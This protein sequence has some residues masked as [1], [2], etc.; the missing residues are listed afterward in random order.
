[1]KKV[2]ALLLFSTT[3]L[4]PACTPKYEM[5]NG[6]EIRPET[7]CSKFALNRAYL[8]GANLSK[9]KLNGVSLR[10]ADLRRAVLSGA[11]LSQADLREANLSKTH[12]IWT[13]LRGADLSG[14][15]LHEAIYEDSTILPEGFDPDAKGM[16]L[17]EYEQEYSQRISCGCIV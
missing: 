7:Q 16:V 2:L 8:H 15:N 12:L 4:L 6:C 14:A 1:M 9:A 11:H 3:V 13:N 17:V 10:A 5:V